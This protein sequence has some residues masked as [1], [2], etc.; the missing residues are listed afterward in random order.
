MAPFRELLYSLFIQLLTTMFSPLSAVVSGAVIGFILCAPLQQAV[1]S[2]EARDCAA[3]TD[4]H[5]LVSDRSFWGTTKLCIDNR[6]L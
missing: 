1:N 3:H 4:T 6:Y 2:W 5:T